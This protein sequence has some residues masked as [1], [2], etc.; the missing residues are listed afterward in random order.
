MAECKKIVNAA[1][2]VMGVRVESV[3]VGDRAEYHPDINETGLGQ[4]LLKSSELREGDVVSMVVSRVRLKS[5][6]VITLPEA[7]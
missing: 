6:P 2:R 3:V 4:A 7:R 5:L 1:V